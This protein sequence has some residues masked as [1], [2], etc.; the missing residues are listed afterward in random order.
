MA[1]APATLRALLRQPGILVAPGAADAL[2]AKMVEAAG[3]SAAYGTGG[4]ISRSLGLPDVG[5]M[6]LGELTG[7]VRNIAEVCRLPLIVD[8]DSGYGS[9]FTLTRA[10]RMLETAGA[11]AMHIEDREVPRRVRDAEANLFEIDA[12]AARI[13]AALRARSNPDFV[14]I[15]R[16]EALPILGLDAAVQRANRYAEAGADMV[17]VE[18]LRDRSHMEAVAA[19]VPAP[20]LISQNKGQGEL[21][22]AAVLGDMGYKIMTVPADAQ[23]AAIHNM[24]AMLD[25]LREHGSN[26]D[27][28]AMVT[29]ADRDRAIGVAETRAME[30]ELLP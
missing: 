26:A 8:G 29:F 23:L 27:F 7:R 1:D 16:T 10:V 13:R 9:V 22:P 21:L 11:A 2:T 12:M 18:Y 5:L 30:E 19:R 4:G 14:I 15:A 24:K 6:T 20:K 25:H 28:D 17:Y 3:F